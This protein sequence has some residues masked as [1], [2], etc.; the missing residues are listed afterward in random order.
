MDAPGAKAVV[1]SIIKNGGWVNIDA[2]LSRLYREASSIKCNVTNWDDQVALFEHAF[3]RYGAV[4]IV[5]DVPI[6][7]YLAPRK[8]SLD[9]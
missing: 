5:V 6:S 1:T 9:P 2:E 3:E 7:Y 8:L 4:D